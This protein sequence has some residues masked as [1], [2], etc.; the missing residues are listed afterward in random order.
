MPTTINSTI[1]TSKSNKAAPAR[2]PTTSLGQ[3]IHTGRSY[4]P[5]ILIVGPEAQ[6]N[7]GYDAHE[8]RPVLAASQRPRPK[9]SASVSE[10]FRLERQLHADVVWIA[11]GSCE[12][13]RSE[14]AA[15]IGALSLNT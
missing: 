8:P 5:W 2:W 12:F 9:R 3:S 7:L 6:L 11:T 13:S 15:T 4:P 14:G 10:L 1:T